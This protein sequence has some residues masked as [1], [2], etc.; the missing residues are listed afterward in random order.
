MNARRIQQRLLRLCCLNFDHFYLNLIKSIEMAQV[1]KL[2][3]P[4]KHTPKKK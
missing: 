1:N 3:C 4:H 2:F